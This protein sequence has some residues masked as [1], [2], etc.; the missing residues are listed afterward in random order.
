MDFSDREEILAIAKNV[1]DFSES[2]KIS[3]VSKQTVENSDKEES[4]QSE[5][6]QPVIRNES[7]LLELDTVAA[8]TTDPDLLIPANVYPVS[9]STISE[10]KISE[11]PV[12]DFD[13][14]SATPMTPA[15]SLKLKT[16]EKHQ[17]ETKAQVLKDVLC[18]TKAKDLD[19]NLV[20]EDL[21]ISTVS[22][23]LQETIITSKARAEIIDNNVKAIS[24]E[25]PVPFLSK[26]QPFSVNRVE[27]QLPV[28]ETLCK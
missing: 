20:F 22:V 8:S 24:E 11:L 25:T 9:S 18:P 19:L 5:T 17:S 21:M 26:E 10:E 12:S 1:M 3:S 23:L 14:K 27:D 2:L 6:K 13:V 7:L 4:Q 15:L 16:P 28:V